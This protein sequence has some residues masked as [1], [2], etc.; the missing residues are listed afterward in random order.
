MKKAKKDKM[1]LAVACGALLVGG[2]YFILHKNQVANKGEYAS[3]S[4]KEK[5]KER[6]AI[7]GE[8][9]VSSF[10]ETLS[11]ADL[12]VKVKIGDV[13]KEFN[14]P[15][16]G[17]LYNAK[18]QETLKG[19][20]G[21]DIKVLQ[22]GNSDYSFNG[23]PLFAKG[24]EF[25]LVLKEAVGLGENVYWLLGEET[26]I[27]Q[28]VSDGSLK[29]WAA[30]EASQFEDIEEKTKTEAEN[31]G[32]VIQRSPSEEQTVEQKKNVQILNENLFKEKVKNDQ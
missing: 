14:E 24:Q 23:N 25:I 26:Q 28:V 1:F 5:S 16:P 31:K 7:H 4:T 13:V 20:A 3:I 27:Y 2:S 8:L 11:E 21:A 6:I 18:V 29:R 10:K 32:T 19:Q 30:H 12:V 9:D 17:I 15:S 22:Q